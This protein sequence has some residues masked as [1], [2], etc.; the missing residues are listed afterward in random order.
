[1]SASDSPVRDGKMTSTTTLAAE[2]KAVVDRLKPSQP[3]STSS[4][5]PELAGVTQ[6][7]STAIGT[8]TLSQVDGD[9]HKSKYEQKAAAAAMAGTFVGGVP[10]GGRA[11]NA[12]PPHGHDWAPY[13]ANYG[14]S[15]TTPYPHAYPARASAPS[16]TD[17]GASSG[18]SFSVTLRMHMWDA[19][20]SLEDTVVRRRAVEMVRA[21]Q[22]VQ[23]T[24]AGGTNSRVH[25]PAD[26][27][28]S[29]AVP[30]PPMRG[31]ESPAATHGL[32]PGTQAT[33]SALVALATVGLA[34]ASQQLDAHI[35]PPPPPPPPPTFSMPAYQYPVASPTLAMNGG[36]SSN[37]CSEDDERL[38]Q[39]IETR[40]AREWKKISELMSYK[41]SDVQCLHR[42]SKVLRPGLRKGPWTEEEDN[43]VRSLV[44]QHGAGKIKWSQVAAQLPGRLGKQCRERW[45]NHLDP[46]IKRDAWSH[47][48][49]EALH[50]AHRQLGNRWSQ[51][52][53]R[54]PGRTENGVK[55]RFHSAHYRN[56]C[57]SKGLHVEKQT[58]RHRANPKEMDGAGPGGVAL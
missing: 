48:E 37:W 41:F 31:L 17:A 12:P 24:S 2:A 29:G 28:S 20:I 13:G 45:L 7:V 5:S 42:W 9:A 1:M 40:G 34:T 21:V 39:L 8:S 23:E 58:R 52:A 30:A 51:I 27:M 43:I 11:S 18:T 38:L 53:E 47:D 6:N 25:P 15:M 19:L 57:S 35:S 36:R 14:A 44:A 10:L 54:L 4:S 50:E 49:D 56:W 3:P 46:G 16:P 22:L 26:A 32:S 55:N 33:T